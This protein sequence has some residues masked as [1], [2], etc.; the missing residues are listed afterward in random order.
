[1]IFSRFKRKEKILP[2]LRVDIHSHLI[3]GIDDGTTSVKE[4]LEILKHLEQLGY[5]K[6]ITTPHIMY[7]GYTNT[8][9]TILNGL[10]ELREAIKKNKINISIDAA[11]EYYV[12]EGFVKLL[13]NDELLKIS[14]KYILLETSYVAK[15]LMF[16]EV[17]F[18]LLSQGYIPI[19]AHPERYRYIKNI[20][21]EYHTL[22]KL[23]ILFQVNIN[24]F[25]GHYG[26]DAQ[27]KALYLSKKGLID[28]LGTDIH[29]LKHLQTL[30]EIMRTKTF[31]DIFQN[32]TIINDQLR[33][34]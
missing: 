12:D 26:K 15:P 8:K 6:I 30:K 13:D 29:H 10:V 34:I 33:D 16:E 19:L 9:E 1:M 11:A 14:E 20:D 23:G 3:P 7:E 32:N 17:I 5:Q 4:S 18:K 24:S 22:K 28:F 21:A 2:S 31:Y 25:G 27:K